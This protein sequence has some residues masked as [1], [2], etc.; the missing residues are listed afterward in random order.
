MSEIVKRLQ[1]TRRSQVEE[2]FLVVNAVVQ[3]VEVADQVGLL[4]WVVGLL[5]LGVHLLKLAVEFLPLFVVVL[6]ILLILLDCV[7]L[8]LT[9]IHPQSL[10]EREWIDLLEDGLECNE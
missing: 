2:L 4:E 9:R 6:P 8:L 10:L 7:Y 3:L 5:I 1:L